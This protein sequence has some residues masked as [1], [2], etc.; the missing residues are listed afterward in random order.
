[1]LVFHFN[2]LCTS[3]IQ[4]DSY[5]NTSTSSDKVTLAFCGSTSIEGSIRC[6]VTIVGLP[7]FFSFS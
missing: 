7:D 4:S 2:I 5:K 1:M 6:I 3:L